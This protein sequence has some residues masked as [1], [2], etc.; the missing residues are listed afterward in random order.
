MI[1]NLA[2]LA[3]LVIGAAAVFRGGLLQGIVMFFNVLLA[4]TLATAWYEPLAEYL[5]TY[6]KDYANF[7]DVASLWLL[8][9]VILVLLAGPTSLLF[10]TKIA[11]APPVELA[12]SLIVGLMTGWTVAEF[13]ALSL[14][15]A[16]LRSDVVPV[17]PQ[18]MLYGLKPDRCWLWWMQGST[19]NGPFAIVDQ[20]FDPKS[21]FLERHAARRR[22]LSGEPPAA[23]AAN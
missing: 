16:P 12:G 21:D 18:T 23:P 7:L 20:P 22:V 4:A 14:H 1:I 6:L 11:F 5:E 15:T 19:R 8:F 3:V 10:R 2:L 9:A 17:P 13:T